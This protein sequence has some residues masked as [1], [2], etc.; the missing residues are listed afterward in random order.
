MTTAAAKPSAPALSGGLDRAKAV[1]PMLQKRDPSIIKL[2]E[3]SAHVTLYDFDEQRQS[4]SRT[5]IEGSLHLVE[6]DT[7]PRYQLIVVNKLTPENKVEDITPE[8]EVQDADPYLFYKNASG[9]TRGIWFFNHTDLEKF[10]SFIERL[11]EKDMMVPGTAEHA[12]AHDSDE[13]LM[14]FF[15]RV[16]VAPAPAPAPVP[17]MH[18]QPPYSYPGYLYGPPSA[19]PP[20]LA[21]FMTMKGHMPPAPMPVPV[22]HSTMPPPPPPLQQ[23]HAYAAPPP[24]YPLPAP[25]PHYAAGAA[26]AAP[27]P[28]APSSVSS[29]GHQL[30]VS[31]MQKQSQAQPPAAPAAAPAPMT[32]AVSVPVFTTAPTKPLTKAKLKASLKRLADDDEF[33][34]L[35]LQQYNSGKQ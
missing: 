1:L 13:D 14:R 6:R 28:P 9:Q 23:Q 12:Q 30:L 24:P 18:S 32:A 20:S 8:M 25:G 10:F 19:G 3:S 34:D 5:Q 22:P 4:W 7:N 11:S 17:P 16:R 35:V 26:A 21:S 27:P 15:D 29:Q 31:L 33:L 2:V